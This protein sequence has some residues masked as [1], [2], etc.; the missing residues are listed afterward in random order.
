MHF[1]PNM[2]DFLYNVNRNTENRS[3]LKRGVGGRKKERY[4]AFFFSLVYFIFSYF[5]SCISSV[6]VRCGGAWGSVFFGS[7]G[8]GLAFLSVPARAYQALRTSVHC[9]RTA[10]SPQRFLRFDDCCAQRRC[11][12]HNKSSPPSPPER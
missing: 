9:P 1:H 5:F 4:K 6:W 8:G 2:L 7:G 3:Y 11:T 10:V 12:A